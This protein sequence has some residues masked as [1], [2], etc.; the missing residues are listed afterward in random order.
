MLLDEK[1]VYLAS[2]SMGEPSSVSCRVKTSTSARFALLD[3]ANLAS[4]QLDAN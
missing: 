1:R 2:V 4:S 3:R